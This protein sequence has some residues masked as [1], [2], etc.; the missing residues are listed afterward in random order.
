MM[1]QMR[2]NTK[3]IMILAFLAFG[4][5]IFFEWGMDITGQTASSMGVY[6]ELGRVN[7]TPVT[8]DA[9]MASYRYI[10]DQVQSSQEEP[11]TSVQNTEI[12]D[13]AWDEVV[14]AILVQQELR[15]RGIVVTDEEVVNAARFNPPPDFASSPAFQTDGQFDI[16]KYQ[17]FVAGATPEQ[18]MGLEAY[19]RDVIPR[20][21]L[22]R[23]ISSGVHVSDAELWGDYR[24]ENERA[25]VRYVGLDPLIRV[26]DDQIETTA[27]EVSRHYS[28]NREDYAVPTTASV[29]SVALPKVPTPADTAA[30]EQRVAD[31]REAILGGEEFAELAREESSDEGTAPAG[32]DLG[33]FAKGSMVQAF[34][35]AVFAARLDR[36]TEPVRTQFGLHLIE[37]SQRWGQD[38]A[39][40]RHILLPFERTD[41][42]EFD[43]LEMADTLEEL[44][45]SMP[46]AEAA[47]ALGFEADT[48]EM[49]ES[50]PL[51]PGAG[52]VPEGGEWI[53][54]P[55]TAPG[56][57][58]PVFENRGAFYALELVSVDL[59]G[60]LTEVEAET[61]IRQTLGVQKKVAAAM[62]EAQELSDEVRG[63]R[64]LDEVAREMGLEV[65]EAGPFARSEFVPG[66]GFRTAAVGVAFG[67]EVGEVSNAVEANQNAFVVEKTGWEAADSLAWVDQ[68]DAQRSQ[69]VAAVRNQRLTQWIDGLRESAQIVDRREEVLA[70][71]D[72]TQ[73]TGLPPIF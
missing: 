19:Y 20:G 57:V 23:Q 35:S 70:P 2:D 4:G 66:L 64:P 54:D 71:P 3:W 51:I 45:E 39:Q 67:L 33:V 69:V 41:E 12:E 10:Y 40:A 48:L 72:E 22:A 7:G 25:S 65:Q 56:D 11:V 32:G 42:S 15:R 9:Y 5:L 29:I 6:G 1:R 34:D 47:A 36:V 37:V 28:D 52:Q 16:A 60:Y 46:L 68:V 55:E 8:Y 59:G 31:L 53:F 13:Q 43:L 18:L 73:Q 14:N 26:S 61:A 30:V 58:S 21:K 50:F 38:S 44:G 62:E 27:D 49:T 24:N 63:G 17:Q